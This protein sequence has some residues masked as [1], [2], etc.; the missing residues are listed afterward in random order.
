MACSASMSLHEFFNFPSIPIDENK[1]LVFLHYFWDSHILRNDYFAPISLTFF[2]PLQSFPCFKIPLFSTFNAQCP[3]ALHFLCSWLLGTPYQISLIAY[4]IKSMR[5]V[6]KGFPWGL[7][8]KISYCALISEKETK[9][10]VLAIRHIMWLTQLIM[11]LL[12]PTS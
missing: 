5:Q 11:N 2:Y 1:Y 4:C 6:V 10:L 12:T 8:E 7:W 3:L 9:Q